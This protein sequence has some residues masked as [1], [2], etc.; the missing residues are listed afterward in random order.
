MLGQAAVEYLM[1]LSIVLTILTFLTYYAQDMTETNREEIVSSNAIIAVNKIVEASDIVYVQGDSSQI[2]LSVYIPENVNSIDFSNNMIV[3]KM[4]TDP[5]YNDIFATSK[6][7]FTDDSFISSDF[8]TKRVKI[9]AVNVNG[10]SYV[11]VTQV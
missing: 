9:R 2:T 4:C 8:G 10:V 1:V 7:N 5:Y 11:N 6:A 3:I